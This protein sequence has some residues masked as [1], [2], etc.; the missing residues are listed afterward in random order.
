MLEQPFDPGLVKTRPGTF[1]AD[2]SYVEGAEYIKRLN[3]AFDGRWSFE[4][5]RHEITDN[6]AIVVGKL[7]ADGVVK[8]AFGGAEIKRKKESGE[9]VSIADDLKAAATDS[10][11]KCASFLGVGLHLYA[12]TPKSNGNGT[13]PNGNGNGHAGDD[14]S[15]LT[16]RQLSAIVS[17]GKERGHERDALQEMSVERFSR[18]LEFLTKADA[19]ALIDELKNS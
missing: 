6:E 7:S 5:V 17:I 9:I 10:L 3:D 1:G 16:S 15:R 19:S 12:E 11:K 4:V 13:K 14:K 18:R 8:M 2:L